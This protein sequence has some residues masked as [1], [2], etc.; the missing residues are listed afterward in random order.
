MDFVSWR[1]LRVSSD[2]FYQCFK[3]IYCCGLRLSECLGLTIHDIL[4]KENKLVIRQSKGHQYG[5]VVFMER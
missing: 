2:T 1:M 5:K 3:L 4:G